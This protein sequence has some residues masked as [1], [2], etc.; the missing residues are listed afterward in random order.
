[1]NDGQNATQSHTSWRGLI[2][3]LMAALLVLIGVQAPVAAA[4]ATSGVTL[5]VDYG[6]ETYGDTTVVTPGTSYTARLQ[7]SVPDLTP[8]GT[9]TIGVPDGVTVPAEALSV[10]AG[11]TIIA[12]LGLDAAG[13]VVVTFRDPLDRT[14]DQGVVSFDFRFD[15]PQ[16]GT[17]YRDITWDVP[18]APLTTRL[19]VKDADDEL[20]PPLTDRQEKT[21]GD[22]GLGRFVSRA[23]DGVVTL[24][25]GITAAPISYTIA[26]DAADARGGL[27]VSDT[28]SEFLAFD[29]DSFAAE[30]TAWDEDGFNKTTVPFAL[31]EPA[32]DGR[33]FAIEGIDL[34]AGSQLRLTYTAHV[35]AD[36]VEALRAALQEQADA[37]GEDGGTYAVAMK[38][39]AVIDGADRSTTVSIGGWIAAAP[40]PDL[41]R[42][43]SKGSNLSGQTRIALDDE[44]RLAEPVDV[45]YTLRADLTQFAAFVG[46]RH[47]LT[48][49]VVITDA[50]PEQ[51]EWAGEDFLRVTAGDLEL[52]RAPGDV[53]AGDFAG[54]AYVGMYRLADDGKTLH[55]NVGRDTSRSYAFEA[56]ARITT[57]EGLR[58]RQP[59]TEQPQVDTMYTAENT[60]RFEFRASGDE[61]RTVRT[62]L[63][64]PMPPG[65]VINDPAEFRKSTAGTVQVRPGE[66]AQVA[67]TFSL[68][69]G[70]VPDLRK[71]RI[72][73]EVNREVFDLSDLGAI[74]DSITGSYDGQGGLTGADVDLTLNEAGELV[75][76][77]SADFGAGLPAW[78]N[79]DGELT[80]RLELTLTLPT[81]VLEGKQTIDVSNAARVEGDDR[82][83]YTW[84]SEAKGTA[85]SYGDELEVEKTLYSG[86]GEWTQN[87]RVELDDEGQMTQDEFVYRVRLIPHG[88]YFGVAIVPLADAL[89]DGVTFL[90]FVSDAN[91]ESGDVDPQTSVDIGG[92]VRA[93]WDAA[94]NTVHIQQKP[95]TTLPQ[96]A[97][98]H[99]NFKVR[100]DS[101]TADV[102][103]TNQVRAASATITP[104]DGFPLMIL[105]RDTLRPDEVIT[106][107]DARFTVTAP[108]GSVITDEAYVVDGR[109]VVAGPNGSDR[110][111]V[112]PEEP[113]G[114]VPAGRYTVTET[115]AP[116]GYERSDAQLEVTIRE[117]GSSSPATLYNTPLSLFALGDEAW[118]DADRDG[119]RD[120]D[121]DPLAGVTVE[122]LTAG[123]E[124]LRTTTTD[125]AGRYLFDLLP[126]G[127]YRVRFVLTDEQAARY[128]FTERTAGG[129]TTADSDADRESGESG[130][131]VLGDENPHL[132]PGDAYEHGRVRA[133]RGIDPTWDAGVVTK[134]YAIGDVA[135]IDDNRNGVQDE[136]EPALPGV[137]VELRDEAG[138][139]L[140]TAE[141]DAEGRYLFDG[142]EAGD[143]R[144]RFVLDEQQRQAYVFTRSTVGDAAVDS[145]AGASEERWIGETDVIRLGDENGQLTRD[146]DTPLSATEG[147]DP[148]WDAGV[149]TWSY[150]IGDVVWIDENRDG[151]Q[152]E[153]EPALPGVTVELRTEAGAL[154]GTTVTDEE[155]RYLFDDLAEGVY[156]VR[157]T[158]TEQQRRLYE[159][160]L[161]TAGDAASDSDADPAT[162][163][164]ALIALGPDNPGLTAEY[165]HAAL[166]ATH[167]IDPTWDAGVLPKLWVEVGDLVWID[168]NRDGR[169]STG[170]PGIPGVVLTIVGPD[171]K[172]VTDVHGQPVGP[173]KTDENG[174]YLFTGLPVLQE[175]ESYT[176]SIDRDASADALAGLLP[177]LSGIGDRAGDSS[178][179]SAASRGLTMDR[180]QD[181]TLD[182]GFVRPLDAAAGEGEQADR[183]GL[184]TTGGAVGATLIGV[185]V[186]LVLAGLGLYITRRRHDAA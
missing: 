34:P 60:A 104:S 30:L 6:G 151:L 77:P 130:V 81:R 131:I 96:G 28:I 105:K 13:D 174:R 126:A 88:G 142:L 98:A 80:R 43:F 172:P 83:E 74:R 140:A 132:V 160:T 173:Q 58:T 85:T 116:A 20:R 162:G 147:I 117:D 63:Y 118:I 182:F 95:G 10:P 31:P 19:I 110:A 39:N 17:G 69:A 135:W 109:L 72:V 122:L 127:E 180:D 92:N 67:F 148:T 176:V 1:M 4:A 14:I 3:A 170:E 50:L 141:T 82:Q 125:E 134:T 93:T 123:G 156:Q 62:T 143:Y 9:V 64:L 164:T 11:N 53:S 18:G 79:L 112:V 91:L 108:D 84:Y 179:W 26:I 133:L 42:A 61:N 40:R 59:G 183:P 65:S 45:T 23:A 100:V 138:K 177:T 119:V 154:V 37:V 97:E 54:D 5:S 157:F 44:G 150:A 139:V 167:G 8:G 32:V 70:S 115:R 168:E 166:K 21:A 149:V 175:G 86:A 71:S 51:I 155:G 111:I 159:F 89:P 171:G 158:L 90:G 52:T 12:S 181:L 99:V 136:G 38:N 165:P 152:D 121:E 124:V 46:T 68:A 101:F 33:T 35:R 144:L 94:A 107:R 29:P 2:A 57:L 129:D 25:D 146:Y 48:R 47:E 27:V 185:A 169:Q 163:L 153:G 49:N 184:A 16:S 41:G 78:M 103:I 24:A 120:G 15:P 75:L 113:D 186:F 178:E 36:Q 161:P 137:T 22:P 7:Y 73:D 145:D 66:R 87:L 56:A 106:D 55:I 102:G 128:T 76:T 114:G